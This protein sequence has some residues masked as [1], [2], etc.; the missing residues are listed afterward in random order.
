MNAVSAP[1][2]SEFK[3][4]ER[5]K[6][7]KTIILYAIAKKIA[8]KYYLIFIYDTEKEINIQKIEQNGQ[9]DSNF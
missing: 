6:A 3:E 7:W 1:V 8:E 9:T 2:V 4:I 5:T